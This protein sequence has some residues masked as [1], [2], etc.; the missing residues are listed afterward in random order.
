MIETTLCYVEQDGKYLMLYRN[1]KQQDPNAGK[2]IGVGGKL[3]P[4]ETPEECLLRE[5]REETGLELTEYQYRGR[6]AF[7]P[8]TWEDEIMYLYTATG[9]HRASR[10]EEGRNCSE[11]E[12]P[13][14]GEEGWDC[15]EGELR[16]VRFEEIPNLNL[17]EGDRYFLKE[18]LEGK[19]DIE[20]E[21]HYHGDELVSA[22][23]KPVLKKENVTELLDKKFLNLYDYSYY[24]GRHYFVATRRAKDDLVALKD[25][26][27]FREM[28]PDAVGCVVILECK[29]EEPR[30]LL[31]R[32]MRFATGQFLL[33]VPAGLLD[34]EDKDEEEPIFT[35][36]IREL[37]E[38]TGLDFGE[39][40]EIKFVNRFL[41]SSP[42]MTDESNAM[43]QITLRR[44]EMPTLTQAGTVGGECIGGYN[45][46]TKEEALELLKKG[47]DEVG[48]YYS[49]YTWIALM[50]FVSG[51]WK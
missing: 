47:T 45:L 7:L 43:V 49:V 11:G 4:G 30:L 32:E 8:D 40:D 34:P 36:A 21:L 50:T 19:N 23:S 17:W 41:F 29:G 5:V 33:G 38:E 14:G 10:G 51:I 35:A 46:Y 22:V 2:W 6:I 1:K 44:E 48:I 25:A 9:F 13:G 42:G 37:S 24:P 28:Q 31:A 12:L 18:L 3:E 39:H 27:A 20:M 26:K 16:W 15:P